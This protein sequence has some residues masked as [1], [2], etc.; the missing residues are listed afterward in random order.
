MI[1]YAQLFNL[2]HFKVLYFSV[3]LLR[4]WKR[5]YNI[6]HRSA[7]YNCAYTYG[8]HQ[9]AM[10]NNKTFEPTKDNGKFK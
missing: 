3:L 8:T 4:A 2:E 5:Y 10:C 1:F 7:V 9:Y 6:W